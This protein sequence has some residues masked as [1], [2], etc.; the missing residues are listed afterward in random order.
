VIVHGLDQFRRPVEQQIVAATAVKVRS[1]ALAD[2]EV[3]DPPILLSNWPTAPRIA[4]RARP[5]PRRPPKG[6][7]RNVDKPVGVDDSEI[8]DACHSR[9]K[10]SSTAKMFELRAGFNPGHLAAMDVEQRRHLGRRLRRRVKVQ[11]L[12]AADPRI[13]Q[14]ATGDRGPHEGQF[15]G[16]CGLIVGRATW[17]EPES[18]LS[19]SDHLTA[20]ATPRK[21]ERQS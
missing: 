5:Q 14:G 13:H 21:P 19:C 3:N 16:Y 7:P 20:M 6:R 10:S 4:I 15:S 18:A 11:P 8:R 17:E 12:R 9:P 1:T 2:P